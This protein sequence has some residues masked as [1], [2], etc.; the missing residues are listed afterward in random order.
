MESCRSRS[1]I[2][3]AACNKLPGLYHEA[4]LLAYASQNSNIRPKQN[5]TLPVKFVH[6]GTMFLFG[7]SYCKVTIANTKR[8]STITNL[9]HGSKSYVKVW[10]LRR[11]QAGRETLFAV[12]VI[13]LAGASM[14]ASQ[15]EVVRELTQ[16][17]YNWICIIIS[18]YLYLSFETT[19]IIKKGIAIALDLMW[20]W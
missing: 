11:S 18:Q 13:V 3:V 5:I 2:A 4:N 17:L 8:G 12:V 6:R 10:Q 7:S 9:D 19:C 1:L 16:V 20:E 14:A 15:H